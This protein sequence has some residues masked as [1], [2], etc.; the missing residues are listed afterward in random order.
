MSFVFV[1]S[2]IFKI[3]K[4]ERAYQ[5]GVKYGGFFNKYKE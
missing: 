4:D 5:S 2:M 3:P 1:G